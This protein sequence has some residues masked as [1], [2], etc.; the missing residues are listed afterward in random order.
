[1]KEIYSK[2]NILHNFTKTQENILRN[3]GERYS[4]SDLF[5]GFNKLSMEEQDTFLIIR[6]N[7]EELLLLPDIISKIREEAKKSKAACLTGVRIIIKNPE[8]K[9][10]L[11][12]IYSKKNEEKHKKPSV[13]EQA[14]VLLKN[15]V[16][17]K[18]EVLEDGF[19]YDEKQ[20]I[21][22]KYSEEPPLNSTAVSIRL[23][24][25]Q[26][27]VNDATIKFYN[28]TIR[29]AKIKSLRP[30]DYNGIK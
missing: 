11:K 27:E 14:K 19:G 28:E 12:K 21:N 2:Q 10:E 16:I 1:M 6:K 7:Q 3:Y 8:Y 29:K 26:E 9:F 22:M 23:C 30:G 13:S 4:M 15:G 25:D 18:E 20:I 24:I 5:Y 17:T